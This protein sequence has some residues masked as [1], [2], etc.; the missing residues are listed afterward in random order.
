MGLSGQGWAQ[1]CSLAVMP[2]LWARAVPTAVPTA[3]RLTPARARL[4][5]EPTLLAGAGR[6]WGWL[7]CT[8][9]AG[10]PSARHEAVGQEPA[11]SLTHE[12]QAVL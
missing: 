8:G 12:P 6:S 10:H 5:L 7:R 9:R 3:V 2:R 11:P 4:R 1:P